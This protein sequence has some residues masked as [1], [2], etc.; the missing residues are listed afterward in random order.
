MWRVAILHHGTMSSPALSRLREGLGQRGLIDGE[1]C[2]ID[3]AGA[4]GRLERLPRLI[5]ELL[6]RAPDVVA[7]I[8]GVAALAA[9]RATST[10]PVVHAIVL[11]PAKIGLTAANVAGITTF[12]PDHGVRQL[13]LLMELVPG[14]RSFACLTDPDAPKGAGGI[15]PLLFHLLRAAR[16]EG[17]RVRCVAQGGPG[18]DLEAAFDTIRQ[19]RAEALVALEVPAVLARLGEI[20]ALAERAGLPTVFPPGQQKTGVVML[21]P[22][23]FDAV[24]PLAEYIVAISGGVAVAELTTHWVR[25]ERLEVDVGRARRSG[26]AVPASI[27]QR[28]TRLIDGGPCFRGI[29]DYSEE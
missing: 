13:R 23:L 20:A 19:P 4:E 11:D 29:N 17:L 24:D 6:R 14:L 21:G 10:I 9:Q 25:H 26:M 3:T 5:G 2:V 1:N 28:A 22:T 15:N 7:A 12:D 16:Q 8:G 27:R 18:S